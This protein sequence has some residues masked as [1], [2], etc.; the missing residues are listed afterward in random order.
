[1]S[2]S[3]DISNLY[4]TLES[5]N[6]DPAIGIRVEHLTGSEEFS[7]FGAEIGPFKK[8][9]AHYHK[10]GIETYQVIEGSGI[11][12]IGIPGNDNNIN[13]I[14]SSNVE[15]GDCFTVD[16]GEVHQLINNADTRLVAIFGCP[17]SHLSTDR[18]VVKGYG[19]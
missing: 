11:M 2:N 4:K 1:M 10:I 18:I 14:K 19:E 8:V 17:K 16:A 9:G 3:I 15:K 7:L 5:A 6:M 12:H 13:W